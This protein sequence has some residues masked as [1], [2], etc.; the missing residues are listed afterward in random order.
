MI[1]NKAKI[2]SGAPKRNPVCYQTLQDIVIPA[3]TILRSQGEGAFSVSVDYGG[4][5]VVY[6]PD[7]ASI[8]PPIFKKV[9][10]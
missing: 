9:I 3:G 4:L 7:P 5:S 1:E 10:A 6:R 8:L 2:K